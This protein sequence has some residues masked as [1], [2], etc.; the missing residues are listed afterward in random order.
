V[1]SLGAIYFDLSIRKND[2]AETNRQ[3]E[4]YQKAM[5]KRGVLFEPIFGEAKQFVRTS[6]FRLRELAKVNIEGVMVAAGQNLKR[7][8]KSISPLWR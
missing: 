4:E 8:L 6:F 2:Q 1:I 3:T 7:S 5:R